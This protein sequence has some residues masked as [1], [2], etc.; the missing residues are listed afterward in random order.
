MS[1]PKE[2]NHLT[3]KEFWAKQHKNISLPQTIR[4]EERYVF[5]LLD[6]LFKKHLPKNDKFTFLEIGCSP[7]AWMI[8][9]HKTFG[10]NVTGI[11]YTTQGYELTKQNLKC[12]NTPGNVIHEDVFSTTLQPE[13]FDVVVSFG[14]IEH[15]EDQQEII[16]VHYRLLKKGGI[17]IIGV[18]NIFEDAVYGVV[19]RCISPREYK[20]L[21][22]AHAHIDV[23]TLNVQIEK[24]PI[25]R[26]MC[27]YAGVVNFS[28]V[29]TAARGRWVQLAYSI[30]A[31]TIAR[32][33]KRLSIRRETKQFSP[34]V[35]YI[36][37]KE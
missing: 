8:Y 35:F 37:K 21:R 11:E 34:Y 1:N 25:K 17:L 15:F 24:H 10:Y 29:N 5:F 32:W 20:E 3:T 31:S 19:Q 23:E 16:D 13:S 30:F 4:P 7:G 18:P 26:L 12:T 14:F 33:A 22:A 6:E 27:D 28:V 2:D 36:G 9:F